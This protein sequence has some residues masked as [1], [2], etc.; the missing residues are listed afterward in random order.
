L[1]AA[2][3]SPSGTINT[4]LTSWVCLNEFVTDDFGWFPMRAVPISWIDHPSVNTSRRTRMSSAPAAFNIS[5]A[6]SAMSR[7]IFNSL[8]PK[9]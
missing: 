9:R 6:V 7:A 3:T 5:S 4:F 8:S 2:L 1:S